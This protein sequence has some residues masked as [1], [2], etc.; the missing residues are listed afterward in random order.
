MGTLDRNSRASL[1][2]V[3]NWECRRIYINGKRQTS[4]SVV[5]KALLAFGGAEPIYQCGTGMLGGGGYHRGDPCGHRS[6][7]SAAAAS[8]PR[9]RPGPVSVVLWG[10]L[11]VLGCII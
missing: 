9:G 11:T 8:T 10:E 2:I 4:S 3:N 7:A 5:V 1:Q 6:C